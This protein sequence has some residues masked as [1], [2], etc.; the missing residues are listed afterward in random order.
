[1]YGPGEFTDKV[2]QSRSFGAFSSG[3]Q[4]QIRVA[5]NRLGEASVIALY[6]SIAILLLVGTLFFGYVLPQ[7]PGRLTRASVD[8]IPQFS[9]WSW[10]TSLPVPIPETNGIVAGSLLYFVAITFV[11]YGIALYLSWMR[12]T[13]RHAL[14]L[15]VGMGILFSFANVWSLPNLNTDIY[16]YIVDGR[17]AAV[18]G[19]NPYSVA[20]DQFPDDPIYP[21]ASDRFTDA[22]VDKLPVWVGLTVVLARISGDNPV[23]NLLIFR[24]ALFLFNALNLGLVI[25]VVRALDARRL[26]TGTILYSWNPIIILF[27]QSKTDTVMAFFILLAAWALVVHR[28]WFFS[29]AFLAM[30]VLVKLI[31]LPLIALVMLRSIKRKRWKEIAMGVLGAVVLLGFG[32]VLLLFSEPDGALLLKYVSWLGAMGPFESTV[33]N[34]FILACFILILGGIGLVQ[35]SSERRLFVGSAVVMLYLVFLIADFTRAWYM[36]TVVALVSIAVNRHLSIVAWAASL[37]SF[38][39][40]FW[41]GTF[42][43]EFPSP[44]IVGVERGLFLVAFAGALV[45]YS[46]AVL[47]RS[48]GRRNVLN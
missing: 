47:I 34:T 15:I 16:N 32:V 37:V 13:S 31:T 48:R 18:Y 4:E 36:I 22:P 24:L 2:K 41:N 40:N 1:M 6:A 35:N 11:A 43:T 28:H 26:A 5:V 33:V 38:L 29:L 12:S 21:Y 20:S 25:L 23:T 7:T 9:L 44:D 10:L 17:V 30:S 19:E 8:L 39:Y 46:A 42:T 14:L 45:A 3:W 27:A